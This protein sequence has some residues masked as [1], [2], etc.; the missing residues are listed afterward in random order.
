MLNASGERIGEVY[1]E[2]RDY[3]SDVVPV[4]KDGKWGF[5]DCKSQKVL[6]DCTFQRVL[7]FFGHEA[8]VMR[9]GEEMKVRFE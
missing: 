7:R 5:I 3:Q 2:I 8:I 9:N 4:Q 1:D 6:Y